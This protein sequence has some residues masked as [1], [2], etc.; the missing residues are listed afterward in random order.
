MSISTNFLSA[1][2]ATSSG[3][4]MGFKEV[5]AARMDFLDFPIK[6][7]FP[8]FKKVGPY[9]LTLDTSSAT[10]H[11]PFIFVAYFLCSFLPCILS[12]IIVKPIKFNQAYC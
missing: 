9:L 1:T 5:D 8:H 3:T 6:L 7:T 11:D 12:L 2:S 10:L 4:R